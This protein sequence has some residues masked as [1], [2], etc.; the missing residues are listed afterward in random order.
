MIKIG[1]T[2]PRPKKLYGYDNKEPYNKLVDSLYNFLL[3]IKDE[4]IIATS[5]G[6]QGYD[7]IAFWCVHKFK[8]INPKVKNNVY[9]PFL[10]QELNWN[11]TGLFGQKEYHLMLKYADEVNV[12]S[13]V[14]NNDKRLVVKALFERNKEIVNNSDIIIGAYNGDLKKL[15]SE[16]AGG[17]VDC[18][19]Y[20]IQRNKSIYLINPETYIIN[21][22]KY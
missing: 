16:S 1:F 10:G 5:G 3:K 7:Q 15:E 4:E 11:P 12:I 22:L 20:S 13:N 17:T 21:K 14:D 9:I 2:G 19:K 6:A 18:L 8:S